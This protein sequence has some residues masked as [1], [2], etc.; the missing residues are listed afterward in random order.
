M[1]E[2]NLRRKDGKIVKAKFKLLDESYI[3]EIMNLQDEI[4]KGLEVREFYADSNRDMFLNCIRN[5][6]K[7]VGCITENNELVAIGSYESYG[8][9]KENYGYDLGLKNE[10]L[11]D[12]GQLETTI[13]REDYRGNKLQYKLCEILEGFGIDEGKK[14]LAVTVAPDNKYSLNTIISRGFTIEK[15]KIKYGGYRRYILKKVIKGE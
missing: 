15:E 5:T 10:E 14:I 2:L 9:D 1:N 4:I 11:L 8:Y 7:I 12:V 3:D 13:V 6:G